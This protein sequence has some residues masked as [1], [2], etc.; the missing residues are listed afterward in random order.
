MTYSDGSL[1]VMN[2]QKSK[3]DIYSQNSK[4]NHSDY[5]VKYKPD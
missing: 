1:S 5:S 4:E 2:P 3:T